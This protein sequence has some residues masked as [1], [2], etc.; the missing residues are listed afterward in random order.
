MDVVFTFKCMWVS[1][2]VV[3]ALNLDAC[4]EDIVLITDLFGDTS[5]CLEWIIDTCFNMTSQCDLLQ[6]DMPDV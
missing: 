6:S 3:R 5:K 1:F 2:L 4:V